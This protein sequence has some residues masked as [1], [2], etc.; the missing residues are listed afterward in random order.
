VAETVDELIIE[1]L[2][3]VPKNLV[4]RGFG[5]VAEIPLPGP[6]QAAVNETF[7]TAAGID[8]EE[9]RRSPSR[10]STL[11]AF[12]TRKLEAEA[13]SIEAPDDRTAVSPVDG[14][15]SKF[16]PIEEETLVQAKGCEYRLLDLLDSGR[17]AA[18]FE[19]GTYA[20]LYLSPRD[21]HR[22]HSPFHGRVTEV[23][24][25]PGE[26]FPVFPIAVEQVDELFCVNERLISFMDVGDIGRAAV[27]MV[28]ATCVG[29]ISLSFHPYQTNQSHRRRTVDRLAESVELEHGEELGV[30]NLGSTVVVLFSTDEFAFDDQLRE[31]M[32][33]EMGQ[34]LGKWQ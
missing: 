20:T 14:T 13:R 2:E 7:A 23:S 4:S 31:G 24:Y 33:I 8:C 6:V 9:A 16:G 21:Y 26:L 17:H 29:R 1:F 3:L 22:V 27:V 30:F 19:H 18:E 10:Y 28:G 34:R 25:I 12:F 11:N 32:A 15:L 5:A